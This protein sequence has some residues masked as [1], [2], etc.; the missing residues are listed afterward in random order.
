MK[1]TILDR[2]EFDGYFEISYMFNFDLPDIASL[3]SAQAQESKKSMNGIASYKSD[4]PIEDVQ[5]DLISRYEKEINNLR[6]DKQFIYYG[7]T[8]DG[9]SWSSQ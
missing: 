5:R 3:S 9:N 6:E 1:I 7:L 4:T 8:Y 2:K